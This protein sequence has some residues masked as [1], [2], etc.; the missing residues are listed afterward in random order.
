MPLVWLPTHPCNLP[1]SLITPRSH[2]KAAA[3]ASPLAPARSPRQVRQVQQFQ[4]RQ[5][6]SLGPPLAK[7]RPLVEAGSSS[8]A[9][10]QAE[11]PIP[12]MEL[13]HVH[14]YNGGGP[15]LVRM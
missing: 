1:G 4:R 9:T 12:A 15:L 13:V 10:V 5:H 8:G 11:L 2:A 3:T 7:R 6:A 14:G